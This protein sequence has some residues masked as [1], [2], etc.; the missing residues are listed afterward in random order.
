MIRCN[1]CGN[2]VIEEERVWV[3]PITGRATTGD[4]GRPFHVECAPEE[5]ADN[6]MIVWD[7]DREV[8]CEFCL[9]G[10]PPT[11]MRRLTQLD[12]EETADHINEWARLRPV[13]SRCGRA[14]NA[15]DLQES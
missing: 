13:C 4:K 8:R 5:K 6:F 9:D 11:K 2:V 12:V 15:E 14:G 3:D 10:V 1:L 7:G